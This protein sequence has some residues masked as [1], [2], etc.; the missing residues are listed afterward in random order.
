M[1]RTTAMGTDQAC[2][3]AKDAGDTWGPGRSP[4]AE[5]G[6]VQAN[7]PNKNNEDLEICVFL[8]SFFLTA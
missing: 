3:R 4:R 6:E 5:G 2:E 1:D 7:L 8:L